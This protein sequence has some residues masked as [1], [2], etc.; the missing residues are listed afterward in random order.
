MSLHWYEDDWLEIFIIF[1]NI[2]FGH[3]LDK[4]IANYATISKEINNIRTLNAPLPLF[5]RSIV[6][7][8][9]KMSSSPIFSCTDFD[10]RNSYSANRLH[11]YFIIY[12]VSMSPEHK[13]L[14][15]MTLLVISTGHYFVSS[16]F[17]LPL[18]TI[19]SQRSLVLLRVWIVTSNDE[20]LVLTEKKTN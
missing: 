17:P 18:L 19:I 16:S 8:G 6:Y 4:I 1:R 15:K 14:H 12:R 3:V 11:S 7:G 20:W 9:L 10:W 13:N 2:F 5:C